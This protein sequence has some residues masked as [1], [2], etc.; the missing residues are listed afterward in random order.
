MNLSGII[1][2]GSI[3]LL[4]CFLAILLTTFTL[5]ALNQAGIISFTGVSGIVITYNLII[6]YLGY[7]LL[8][9]FPILFGYFLF[10]TLLKSK[11]SLNPIQ[12]LEE[13][14]NIQFNNKAVDMFITLF[15]GVG[16]LFTAWGLQNALVSAIGG[17]N[18]VEAG[19][20]GAWGILQRLVN[21]GILIA[22]WTTI[23]G[24]IGGYLMRLLKHFLIGKQLISFSNLLIDQDR[25]KLVNSL[26]EVLKEK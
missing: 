17:M 10:L 8:F 20:L 7:S 11:L 3:I 15:F 5:F 19:Q 6:N 1:K 23:V 2:S 12:V 25:D 16:V 22:L 13:E 26:K 18:K 21:N 9:F 4:T 14:E 24:G